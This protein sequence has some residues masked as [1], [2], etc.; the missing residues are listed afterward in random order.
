MKPF[1]GKA[2]RALI[3]GLS[4]LA[5]A[6]VA[7]AY[8][9]ETGTIKLMGVTSQLA[10]DPGYGV[11]MTAPEELGTGRCNDNILNV[12][13]SGESSKAMLS[14]LIAAYN[15]SRT[16]TVGYFVEEDDSC[17]LIYATAN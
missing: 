16:V 12:D 5:C 13:I 6:G 2:C 3:A 10:V 14:I 7:H 9:T 15:A 4:F 1:N 17:N 11:Q 8:D